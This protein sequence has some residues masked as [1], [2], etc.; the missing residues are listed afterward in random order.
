MGCDFFVGVDL[1][2][3]QD[4]SAIVV[5]ERTDREIKPVEYHLRF[6]ERPRLG[7]SY[8]AIIERVGDVIRSLERRE[9]IV[10]AT[11]VGRP[12]LEQFEAA[13]LYPIGVTITGGSEVGQSDSHTFRVPKRDLVSALQVLLQSR[14]LKI[15]EKLRERSAV[16]D[17]LLAFR[18][19]ISDAGFDSYAAGGG[20]H[21]DLVIALALACWYAMRSERV[22]VHVPVQGISEYSPVDEDDRD[23]DGTWVLGPPHAGRPRTVDELPGA[24]FTPGAAMESARPDWHRKRKPFVLR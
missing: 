5:V 4:Y 2:Q 15:A 16:V 24:R 3:V 18:A 10:D 7:T 20:V 23:D 12:V 1:G 13:R 11:G 8:A 6:A 19:N 17:E 21:D 14:R 9:L 22:Y